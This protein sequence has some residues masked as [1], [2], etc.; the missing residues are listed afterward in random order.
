MS[1]WARLLTRWDTGARFA[2]LAGD[3]DIT[4]GITLHVLLAEQGGID[5]LDVTLPPGTTRYP[6]LTADVPG[7][8]WYERKLHDLFGLIPDGHPRLDSL[9]LPHPDDGEPLPSPGASFHPSHVE[10]DE[11]ALHRHVMG[12][13]MFS[14]PHGPVR[15]GVF[16]SV[17]YVVESPGED[18]PHVNVRPHFKHRGLEVR[19]EGMHPEQG[20]LLA[21]RVEGIASVAHALAFCHAVEE[22]A[23]AQPP[24]SAQ[25][26][27]VL[28]A[29][30][31]RVANHLDV[32][33]KL[34]DAAG[35]AVAVARF[36]RH[37]E[38]VL[39]LVSALCGNRFGRGV[40]VPGGVR[41]L[42]LLA[43]GEIRVRLETLGHAITADAAA[44]MQTASFLDRLRDTGPLAEDFASAWGLLGP[45][46]RASGST[47]DAR[48]QR[49]YD[50][51]PK[52]S[53]QP[54]RRYADGDAMARLRVRWDEVAE[55]FDLLRQVLDL[56]A[57]TGDDVPRVPV[58][59][60]T[61]QSVGWAEAPQGEVL[62]LIRTDAAGRLRRCAPRSASFH[63]LA[64][65]SHTFHGDIL[66]DFPFIEASFGLSIAGVVM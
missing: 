41:A 19:F 14:I 26:V 54:D 39:R 22:L 32:A 36:G 9:V 31:E 30:L 56:L 51:Y 17:E 5:T 61:G 23:G 29:E 60:G 4:E 49:P 13:G 53:R 44:L 50:A 18:I 43:A 11:R 2:G 27:R 55:S 62:Y 59:P 33:L 15:S 3:G 20:V 66:T 35:L 57:D 12:T 46:G 45:V 7:A 10:P 21:E 38:C 63:N 65:F 25:L 28:H 40:V 52:L 6:C 24:L 64:A 34:A 47:D 16:E 58:E 8:F 37:K 48:W 42:P 1:L